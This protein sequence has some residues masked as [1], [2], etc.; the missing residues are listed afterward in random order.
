MYRSLQER[1]ADRS[2]ERPLN[3]CDSLLNTGELELGL[4][5]REMIRKRVCKSEGN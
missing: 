4:D 2:G 3:K 1:N 5:D